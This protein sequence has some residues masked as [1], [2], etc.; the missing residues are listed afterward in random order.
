MLLESTK[1]SDYTNQNAEI[2]K[3][4][5]IGIV[6]NDFSQIDE[7]FRSEFNAILSPLRISIFNYLSELINIEVPKF[8]DKNEITQIKSYSVCLS[9]ADIS[10]LLKM[11]QD[12][13]A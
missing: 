5:V 2:V 3:K 10:R 1:I 11:L 13:S 8:N 9:V 12:T 7:E 4:V 6:R